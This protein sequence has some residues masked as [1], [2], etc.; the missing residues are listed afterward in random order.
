MSSKR[1]IKAKDFV[2]DLR[3]GMSDSEIRCKYNL[4]AKG[5]QSAFRKLLEVKAVRT[6]EVF[7]RVSVEADTVAIA[8]TRLLPRDELEFPV[9]IYLCE[10]TR[11]T[12]KGVIKDITEK[13]LKI[14]GIDAKVNEVKTFAIPSDKFSQV[15][16]FAFRAKCRWVD[17]D[18]CSGFQVIQISQRGSG[19]L[20]KL[21]R[22]LTLKE[23][24]L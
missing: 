24:N 7:G 10:G 3:S 13:G 11:P 14:S 4:S 15:E 12:V 18:G 5:L 20:Q 23:A 22:F 21:I 19:E 8:S 9:P 6:S 1:E 17:G 16:P 2:N